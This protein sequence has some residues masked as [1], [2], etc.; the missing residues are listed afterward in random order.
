MLSSSQDVRR[1]KTPPGRVLVGQELHLVARRHRR[2]VD[3]VDIRAPVMTA[4]AGYGR[5]AQDRIDELGFARASHD[6][7]GDPSDHTA[8]A[9][10]ATCG[11]RATT[12]RSK[13]RKL[14]T[15]HEIDAVVRRRVAHR[16]QRGDHGVMQRAARLVEIDDVGSG[17]PGQLEF[18]HSH[19]LPGANIPQAADAL[20]AR[21]STPPG[22][23]GDANRVISAAFRAKVLAPPRRRCRYD[24]GWDR[25]QR[26]REPARPRSRR[27][28]MQGTASRPVMSSRC[29]SWASC[30]RR[31]SVLALYFDGRLTLVIGIGLALS[32]LAAGVT[33]ALIARIDRAMIAMITGAD[34]IGRGWH[35]EP[36]QRSGVR[37]MR[38]LEDA[39]D[40]MREE[41]TRTTISRDYL[42][43]LLNSMGDAVLVATADGRI[44]TTNAA[45]QPAAR[46]H[47]RASSPG[48][49]SPRSIA[50]EHRAAFDVAKVLEAPGETVV[51]TARG[52]TIPVAVTASRDLERRPRLPGA[53][54]RPARHH[55]AQA[56]GTTHP[57]PRALRHAHQDAE[58]HA[59][60][61]PAAAGDR[62]L[63]APG[64]AV[65]CCC[66]WISTT[67][68]TS[69]TR[70][71]TRRA[72]ASSKP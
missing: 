50:P 7:A 37:E 40:R 44:R 34:R 22:G 27:T 53:H 67:S 60:P 59:V 19:P 43:T 13:S 14:E 15:G 28:Q 45:A 21:G 10:R 6:R 61:A 65:W 26:A 2:G 25:G 52:Q 69:T 55:R 30:S 48:S 35:S 3:H 16:E 5:P 31:P 20:P 71:V 58:P 11:S 66:T 1:A 63:D 62:A 72:T 9:R 46:T 23:P 4:A 42:E 36:L 70:S 47:D 8:A 33:A 39:L 24:S 56:R 32:L 64:A 38:A 17:A 68:R 49:S 29:C 57:L 41:L 54:L 18:V 12:C 51:R